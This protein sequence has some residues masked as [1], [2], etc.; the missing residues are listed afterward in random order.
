[1]YKILLPIRY[2]LKRPISW[3]AVLAVSLCVFIVIVVMTV[4][5]GLVED[6]RQKN[7]N[8]VGD[9]IVS[10]DSLVG[11]PYYQQFKELLAKKPFIQNTSA[12]INAYGLLTQEGAKVNMGIQIMGLNPIE[13]DKVTGFGESLYYNRNDVKNAFLSENTDKSPGCIVGIDKMPHGRDRT[14]KYHHASKVPQF[15]LTISCFPLTAKGVLAK[16]GTD[17]VNR[18]TFYVTD[19]S[20]TGLV[21]IDENMIYIPF[22]YAAALTGMDSSQPRASA[23]HIKFADSENLE[24]S[25]KKVRSLWQTFK[26]TKTNSPYIDLLHT[27]KVENWKQNRRSVIAPMEKEQLMLTLLFAMLAV[28]TV[29]VVLV[30]FYMIISHKSRDIGIL[31]SAGVSSISV[32]SIYVIFAVLIG[33]TGSVLGGLSGT[34]FV[35]QANNIETWLFQQFGWQLWDRSVYAI[36]DIPDRIR[37]KVVILVITSAISAS[38]LG[39]FLPAFRAANKK[40]ADVI[41]VNQI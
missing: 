25:V 17:L 7:H 38:V 11:F 14:G 32:I 29:F 2:L 34:V 13:H 10:T 5:N 19:D 40:I 22:E 24:K 4:M 27:V 9:C 31:R 8:F 30:V 20:R 3:V 23:I 35:S 21:K 16:A 1:M 6:F 37:P 15:A 36:G 33:I 12:V 39:A 28:I 18:K 26:K 41:A